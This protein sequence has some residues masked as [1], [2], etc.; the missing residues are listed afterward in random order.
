[1]LLKG[2]HIDKKKL[3]DL[4]AH[5]KVAALHRAVLA[6]RE[7]ICKKPL[8]NYIINEKDTTYS[9]IRCKQKSCRCMKKGTLRFA[10]QLH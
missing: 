1:M 4:T 2:R 6:G 5:P 7:Y 9:I 3:M 10:M 8:D